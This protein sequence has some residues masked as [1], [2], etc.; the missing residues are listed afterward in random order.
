VTSLLK[1]KGTK[2]GLLVQ[3]TVRPLYIGTA[4]WGMSHQEGI[5]KQDK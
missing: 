1:R 4:H 5:S 3:V 2:S